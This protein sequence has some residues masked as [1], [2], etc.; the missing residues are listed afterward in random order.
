MLV[1]WWHRVNGPN[2]CHTEM[3]LVRFYLQGNSNQIE[4]YLHNFLLLF[5]SLFLTQQKACEV[6]YDFQHGSISKSHSKHCCTPKSTLYLFCKRLH[7]IKRQTNELLNFLA[8]V[9]VTSSQKGVKTV[10]KKRNQ[11]DFALGQ[12]EMVNRG[13][14]FLTFTC[15]RLL[16]WWHFI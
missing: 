14:L 11:S 9:S 5:I 3:I 1:W 16:L 6:F 7:I 4:G 12:G 13:R 2:R 8:S 15:L 10:R